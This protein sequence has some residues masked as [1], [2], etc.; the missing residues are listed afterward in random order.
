[1]KGA[2]ESMRISGFMHGVNNPELTKRLNKHVTK[3]MEEM[4]ITATAPIRGEY[5]ALGKKKGHTSWRTQDQSK[6][7]SLEWRSDFRG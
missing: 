1:M 7:N 5:A 4:M 2:L 6:Q 3:T